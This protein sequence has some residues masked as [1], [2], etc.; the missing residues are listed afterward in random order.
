MVL[1][2]DGKGVK[3]IYQDSFSTVDIFLI[4]IADFM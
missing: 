1:K 3:L 2:S 4:V